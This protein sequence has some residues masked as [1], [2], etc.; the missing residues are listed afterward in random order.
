MADQVLP[1]AAGVIVHARNDKVLEFLRLKRIDE[2][3]AYVNTR[4]ANTALDEL[5]RSFLH[6]ADL[7]YAFATKA[8][9]WTVRI[10]PRPI[11]IHYDLEGFRAHRT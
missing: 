3:L 7:D 4:E 8:I 9:D 11:C 1:H 5:V 2:A 6:T 10:D